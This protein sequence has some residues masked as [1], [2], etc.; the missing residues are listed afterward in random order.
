MCL[1]HTLSLDYSEDMIKT[2]YKKDLAGQLGNL[3]NRA[4]A[5]SLLPN[6]MIPGK[7]DHVDPKDQMLHD[8]IYQTAGLY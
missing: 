6:G 4:T 1:T 7:N 2:R 8:Q 5:E 3:L